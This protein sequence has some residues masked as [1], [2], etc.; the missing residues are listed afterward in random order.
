[1]QS[2]LMIRQRESNFLFDKKFL[3]LLSWFLIIRGISLKIRAKQLMIRENTGGWGFRT[4]L[5]VLF[6]YFGNNSHLLLLLFSCQV[7]SNSFATPWTAGCHQ[8]PLSMGFSKQEYW[9]G[10]L[11]PSPG[12]LPN[13]GIKPMCPALASGF[14]TTKPRE[15]LQFTLHK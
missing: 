12:D 15:A 8:A 2:N 13:S 4:H 7:M 9:S 5:I 10:W 6:K 11:F 1:M 14:F 3:F